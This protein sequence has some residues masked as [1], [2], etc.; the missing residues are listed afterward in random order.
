MV[1]YSGLKFAV[2]LGLEG[3]IDVVCVCCFVMDVLRGGGLCSVGLFFYF[4]RSVG[5]SA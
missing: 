3:E 1:F 4:Y 2:F 5:V